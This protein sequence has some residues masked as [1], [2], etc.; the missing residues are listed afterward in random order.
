MPVVQRDAGKEIIKVS[1]VVTDGFKRE[2]SL[3]Y[4]RKMIE[5]RCFEEKVLELY[6]EGRIIGMYHVCI[7]Q[8]AVAVGACAA[9][10]ETDYVA[11]T[12]RGHG[13]LLAR[14]G[15]PELMM[16]ELFG[17]QTGY[18]RGRGGSMHMADVGLGHLGA[19]GIVGAGIPIACG[20]AFAI[21][22]RK[23]EQ[24]V[25]SFFSD[26][27]A[28]QGVFHE[29]L[30]MA[31]LWKLPVV[32]VCENNMYGVSTPVSKTC[33]T[34]N[35]ADKADAYAIPKMIVDGMNVLAVKTAVEEAV[36]NA[37]KGKGPTFVECKTYRFHGHGSSRDCPY[38]TREEEEQWRRKCP[39][40]LLKES[41][42]R[43]K[44]L[45]EDAYLGFCR[46]AESIMAQAVKF[47]E[48]SPDPDPDTVAEHVFCDE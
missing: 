29:S 38:R 16:A 42:L 20:A 32:F 11:S 34:R 14:G 24:V 36:G 35:V 46:E 10:N 45:T 41:L 47:A 17:K 3:L 39:I 1:K 7:G 4:L 9:L 25:L 8:E 13:H 33:P 26:G 37:R 23:T 5:I 21:K 31:A 6:A 18:C 30:N 40:K 48:D 44:L 22:Y 12:H 28:N 15:K 43:K 2:E 19:N 27:A